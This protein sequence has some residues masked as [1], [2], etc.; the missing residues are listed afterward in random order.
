MQFLKEYADC[1][2]LQVGVIAISAF[3]MIVC[4]QQILISQNS[5]LV[6]SL[7]ASTFCIATVLLVGSIQVGK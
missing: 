7:C 4:V 3:Q 5:T 6:N 1:I 2:S